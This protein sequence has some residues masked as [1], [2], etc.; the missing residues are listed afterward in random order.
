MYIMGSISTSAILS[1]HPR[2]W[3]WILFGTTHPQ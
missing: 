2:G 3:T 1:N